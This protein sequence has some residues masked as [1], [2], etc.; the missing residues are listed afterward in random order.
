M[1]LI[2]APSHAASSI[3]ESELLAYASAP[4]DRV[5]IKHVVLGLLNDSP[6]VADY[7]CSDVCPDY[8]VRVIHYELS[9]GQTCNS[10]G[11]VEKALRIPVAIAAT[12]KVFCFPR[13]LVD[14]WEQY[15]KKMS[16]VPSGVG[17]HE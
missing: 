14:N 2:A 7:I 4:Y 12:D 13:V 11:G 15:Q 9:E 16:W 1:S 8:T 5:E 10:V 6:V 17:P 3:S